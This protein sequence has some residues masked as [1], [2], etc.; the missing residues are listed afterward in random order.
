MRIYHVSFCLL[1]YSLHLS[2]S[3]CASLIPF[4]FVI[5]IFLETVNG[6][7]IDIDLT[8]LG[9]HLRNVPNGK[10]RLLRSSLAL[11]AKDLPTVPELSRKGLSAILILLKDM[12][13]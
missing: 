6:K 12:V 13:P 4:F 8:S 10:L 9:S 1:S 11:T 7:V 2:N 3:Q 5:V